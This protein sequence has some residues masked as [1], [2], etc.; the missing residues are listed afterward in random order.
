VIEI[1]VASDAFNATL[2]TSL[3]L[4]YESVLSPFSFLDHHC[5]DLNNNC[6]GAKLAKYDAAIAF[7]NHE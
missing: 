1:A 6:L 5:R 4:L 7:S 2:L 3:L